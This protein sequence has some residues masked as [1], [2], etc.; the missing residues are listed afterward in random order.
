[1]N[2]LEE[3]SEPGARTKTTSRKKNIHSRAHT[4]AAK[5][6]LRARRKNEFTHVRAL[7]QQNK[8]CK[9]EEKWQH[10]NSRPRSTAITKGNM[11]GTTKTQNTKFY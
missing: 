6:K 7:W 8:N 2:K 4:V 9:H 5:Q 11:N 3:K 1:M 10:R